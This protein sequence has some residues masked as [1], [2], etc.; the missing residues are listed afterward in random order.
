MTLPTDRTRPPLPS[1]R[2]AMH[3]V[4]L[5]EGLTG[6]LKALGRRENVTLFMTLL[7]AFKVLLA[8]YSGQDNLVVG[9]PI[10]GRNRVDLEGL[11]GFFVN[12]L[13][14]R[15]DLSGDPTFRELLGRIRESTLDAFA[16]KDLPLA[17]LVEEL[18]PGRSSNQTPLFQVLFALEYLE[19][20]SLRL[21]GLVF[22]PMEFDLHWAKFD[23]SLTVSER[24]GGLRASFNYDTDLFDEGTI[25][26]MAGHYQRLLEGI[27]ADPGQPISQLPLLTED[28][29]HQML[30]EWNDTARGY[31]ADR[32]VHQL[33]EEQVGRTPEAVA[34]VFENQQLTYRELNARS[35]Q[36]ARHLRS[37]GVGPEVLVGLYLERSLEMVVG[38]MG[39]LK[40]GGAYLPLDPSYPA[41]RLGFMLDDARPRVVLTQRSLA[42]ALPPHAS[43]VVCLD[44]PIAQTAMSP[45]DS[46]NR[47]DGP[48]EVLGK[49]S[50]DSLAYVL[51]TSGSTGRPKGVQIPQR[52]V[53]NLL[54]SM[55]R[56]P[57]LVPEDT[58]LAVTT[59]A[60][61]IAALELFLPLTTGACVVIATH[62][63]AADGRRLA[64][65]LEDSRAT[66]MQ[67]TPATWRMLL[68]AGWGGNPKLKV[69][70]G[71]EALPRDLAER[72][73]PLCAELWNLYGPTETTIWSAAWRVSPGQP[74]L[75]GR[76]IANTQFY[77][78]DRLHRP[79]PVG[80]PG[81]LF[82]GGE[83]LARG[84]LNQ[85]ELT[86]E[87]FLANLFRPDSS[88]CL[89]RTGDCV[90]Y[91]PDGCL[92]Y[93]GRL[94]HQVKVR[95][96]RIELGE[97]EV[98]LGQHPQVRER[99]VV[100]RRR[101][102]RRESVGG[103]CRTA[104]QR[105]SHVQAASRLPQA[106][107]AGLHDPVGA[108]GSRRPPPDCQWQAGPAG[109]A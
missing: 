107:T 94:D 80:V 52:A 41:D 50:P 43:A 64:R 38:L 100:A 6:E 42:D 88:A 90:R 17:K 87:R 31:P 37:L 53:V 14:L 11:I 62:E 24:S 23:L 95:G 45:A 51:Y 91:R 57:G 35:N 15:T 75:L 99:V 93:L 97:V 47:G 20:P 7:A 9:S 18:K 84:Y 4:F 19:T 85:P 54:T 55:R 98:V 40:A 10:A 105:R 32:C 60:F 46:S 86:A 48:R 67:A 65:L 70:C 33:F 8:R 12:T 61:D 72:L 28:E 73:L 59:L 21:P 49:P 108:R 69:L 83:G 106:E 56:E 13:A 22:E 102:L 3:T 63:V 66:V 30:V 16:H 34:V 109:V 89:Y 68:G 36:L 39:V 44:A 25:R 76:P 2:G 96:H 82:I 29:R 27:V 92:E 26:R 81:E 5:P 79:V 78:L 104:G 71:G 77:V 103:V 1:Y 74:I 58:F 101:Q